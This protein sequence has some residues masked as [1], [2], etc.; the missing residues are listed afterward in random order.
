MALPLLSLDTGSNLHCFCNPFP[1]FPSSIILRFAKTVYI[2]VYIHRTWP[3]TWWFP[4]QTYCTHRIYVYIYIHGSGQPKSYSM[5]CKRAK[6]FLHSTFQNT[7]R[8]KYSHTSPLTRIH[9]YTHKHTHTHTRTQTHTH[10]HKHIHTSAH[11][12]K[13]THPTHLLVSIAFAL[14]T[15]THTY[16]HHS[17]A[18]K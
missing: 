4:C 5:I 14:Y 15:Y 1:F 9:T 18:G 8:K 17:P 16:T 12:Y 11:T 3:Y 7:L 13:H 2:Y 6:T 10:T